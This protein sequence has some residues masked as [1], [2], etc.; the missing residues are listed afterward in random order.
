MSIVPSMES[1]LNIHLVIKALAVLFMCAYYMSHSGVGLELE[2]D[3]ICSSSSQ[4]LC[5]AT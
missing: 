4:S 2:W 1:G 3:F 5:Y